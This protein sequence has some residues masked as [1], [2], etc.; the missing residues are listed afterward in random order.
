MIANPTA[1]VLINGISIYSHSDDSQYMDFGFLKV[2]NESKHPF[3]LRIF[4]ENSLIWT[5]D[6][7]PED[8]FQNA[9]INIT[10][11]NPAGIFGYNANGGMIND[12]HDFRWM[13]DLAEEVY[14]IDRF[15]YLTPTTNSLLAKLKISDGTF[16]T[17]LKSVNPAN[18]LEIDGKSILPPRPIGRV[19]G[20]DIYCQRNE[21]ITFSINWIG[22]VEKQPVSIPLPRFGGRYWIALDYKC[23]PDDVDDF[24]EIYKLINP[25]VAQKYT[26]KYTPREENWTFRGIVC[27]NETLKYIDECEL[28]DHQTE[29]P[30]EKRAFYHTAREASD[31]GYEPLTGKS[32]EFFSTEFACQSTGGGGGGVP[33]PNV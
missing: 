15:T 27:N 2:F 16:Y 11:T 10:K 29:F 12:E 33:Y 19:L 3:R 28:P 17:Y 21:E 18:I 5:T 20:A 32:K 9:L 24:P 4:K 6:L 31:L 7:Y 13:L 23:I 26:I 25:P 14:G 30:V 8:Y 1:S 22:N